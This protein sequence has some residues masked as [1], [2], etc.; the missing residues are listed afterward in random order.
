[1]ERTAV[2]K[3]REL[4]RGEEEINE[5]IGRAGGQGGGVGP[6][7]GELIDSRARLRTCTHART[8]GRNHNATVCTVRT[9]SRNKTASADCGGFTLHS[10]RR[11]GVEQPQL[12]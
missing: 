4:K 7:T 2:W 9:Q 3:W 6:Y 10:A 11:A 8:D 5:I 12:V 1:M